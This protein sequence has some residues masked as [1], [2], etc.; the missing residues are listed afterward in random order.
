[1]V[2]AAVGSV[3]YAAENN[4]YSTP[5][6][7][8][9][10]LITAGFALFSFGFILAAQ[11][12]RA[13]FERQQESFREHRNRSAETPA[14]SYNWLDHPPCISLVEDFFRRLNEL[15][16][17]EDSAEAR[18][19][20]E[21]YARYELLTTNIAA[22]VILF[23][24]DG[25]VLLCSPYT[26]VLTGYAP[27]EI[28][29]GGE[30]FL[31]ELILEEDRERFHRAWEVARLGEDI[32]VRFR[33]LHRSGLTLWLETRLVPVCAEDDTVTSIMSVSIDVTDIVNYQRQIEE[34][35]RDLKD[36]ASMVSHDLKAP[37]FTIKGMATALLEDYGTKLDKDGREALE[38]IV[39]AGGR[40]ETLVASILTYSKAA[41]A[42]APDDVVRLRDVLETIEQDLSGLIR[43]EHAVIRKPDTLVHLRGNFIHLYQI[44]S[45]LIGN[46]LKYCSPARAPEI[47]VAVQEGP[48][49]FATITVSDNGRG[50]PSNKLD[51]IFRPFQRVHGGPIEGH[52]VGLA[53]V[54]KLTERLGGTVTVRSQE[55]A[56]TEMTV[57]LPVASAETTAPARSQSAGEFSEDVHAI[58]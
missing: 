44:F 57:S 8:L 7:V 12:L 33:M 23:G 10:A 36:F 48:A 43:A 16:T 58:Q 32:F 51:V 18:R 5:E 11:L 3:I 13:S 34:Q 17:L 20:S 45:N 31:M 30:T 26:E 46:A 41:A 14:A 15:R 40:L 52:G 19:S 1:M 49:G 6:Y 55:G 37:I 2:V 25:R 54:K 28:T 9:T 47:T 27:E 24:V 38:H 21:I 53:C 29:G 22:S 56:G 4:L 39:S 35:N 50:I 42:E